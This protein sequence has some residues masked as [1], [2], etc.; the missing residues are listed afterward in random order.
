VAIQSGRGRR[1][2]LLPYGIG[3]LGGV[4]LLVLINSVHGIIGNRVELEPG[5]LVIFSGVD[6]SVGQQRQALVDR[7]NA[8]HPQN[9]A[10]I[11]PL[12]DS[13][14]LQHSAMISQA[15]QRTEQVDVYNLDV[16][17][18]AEFAA[19]GYIR[20][21]GDTS[22]AG[23][24]PGPLKT[25]R[26]NDGRLWALPF[27]TDAGLLYYRTDIFGKDGDG[28]LAKRPPSSQ[29]MVT[30]AAA[31]QRAHGPVLQ[32]GYAIQLKRYEGL[33]VNALEAIWAVGGEVVSDDGRVTVDPDKVQQ[34]LAPLAQGMRA[35]GDTRPSV[36]P[37][38]AKD[39]EQASAE[40][41][42]SGEVALMRNWP[43]WYGRLPQL[44]RG[45]DISSRFS[46]KPIKDSVLGGQNL[47][48][49]AGT[50]RPA[51]AKALVEFL[52]SEASERTLFGA[53]GLPAT[54]ADV[55]RYADVKARQP[56][57]SELLTA[58]NEARPRPVTTHYPLFSDTFQDL[59]DRAL[60]NGG[61]LPSDA[62][63]RLTDA[64]NGRLQ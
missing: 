62:V 64:L 47:A 38:S 56:Y 33:T 36:L 21:F 60:H 63:R 53:G 7:W 14:D 16:T 41:F 27:N 12:P 19:A 50:T 29:D 13:A 20:E 40:A 31:A 1:S 57:A 8:E 3:F 22:T 44:S 24:L 32:A 10:T 51:A 46:V 34:A 15:Q 2:A 11:K 42:A 43:V 6:R 4:L 55:Y 49:A 45:F 48:V 23:F 54:R 61:Q 5:D 25:C 37:G 39:D 30:I 18:T 26:T 9:H 52:T 59:M 58:V 35:V 17:W 28:A